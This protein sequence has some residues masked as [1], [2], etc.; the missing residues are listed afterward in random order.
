MIAI[1]ASYFFTIDKPANF[2]HLVTAIVGFFSLASL[3]MD[4]TVS[5]NIQRSGGIQA[6]R[7]GGVL[8]TRLIATAGRLW[9]QGERFRIFVLKDDARKNLPGGSQLLKEPNEGQ[10]LLN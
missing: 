3:F 10:S 6:M 2:Q 5:R 1:V 8:S 9:A 7:S 4:W